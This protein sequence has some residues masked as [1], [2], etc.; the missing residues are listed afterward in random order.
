MVIFDDIHQGTKRIKLISVAKMEKEHSKIQH[1]VSVLKQE[2]IISKLL[3]VYQYR[4]DGQ[5][6]LAKYTAWILMER[7]DDEQKQKNSPKRM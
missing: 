3:I 4:Q 1:T 2:I 7:K 6:L 5:L